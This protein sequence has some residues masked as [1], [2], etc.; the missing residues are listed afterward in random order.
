MITQRLELNYLRIS[1]P[2]YTV[3]HRDEF[4]TLT[5][6]R[7]KTEEQARALALIWLAFAGGTAQLKRRD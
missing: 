5:S 2:Y 1:R 3:W 6:G 4:G 7:A